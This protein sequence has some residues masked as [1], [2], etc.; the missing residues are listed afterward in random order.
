MLDS[1]ACVMCPCVAFR[2]KWVVSWLTL[3]ADGLYLDR[4]INIYISK[5]EVWFYARMYIYLGQ[6]SGSMLLCIYISRVE[7]W[8]Y[9]PMHIY[10][11][12][13][14]GSMLLCIY[15]SREEVWF[16][17]PMY[18]FLGQKSGSMLLYIHISKVEVWF[19]AHKYIYI[20]GRS[21]VLCSYGL[22]GL[23]KMGAGRGNT[24]A[25][26]RD[27]ALLYRN[28][29]CLIFQ[30]NIFGDSIIPPDKKENKKF[31]QLSIVRYF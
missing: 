17:A 4:Y 21:L 20:Q 22:D 6:K 27:T 1:Y 16:Y 11:G 8:F 12:Q 25:T 5:V 19:Y 24:G 30:Q 10:L 3:I 13:K 18:I 26:L 15:I 28:Q 2:A 14:S 7:V 23:V 29:H 9:A 31:S